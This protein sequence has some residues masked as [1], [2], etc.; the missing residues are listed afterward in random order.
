MP[1]QNIT[2]AEAVA[3]IKSGERVFFSGSS[4]DS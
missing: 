4:N 2:P 1:F 3:N